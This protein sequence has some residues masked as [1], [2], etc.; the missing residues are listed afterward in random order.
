MSRR[1]LWPVV[2]TLSAAGV[3]VGHDFAY[4]FAGV[5]SDG[6]HGYLAH[7]PQ[8]L[9][10]LS[11]P[12]ALVALSGG[13]TRP[14]KPWAFGMLGAA[15]FTAMEHLERVGN[16]GVPWLLTSPLF[17]LGLALQL[18]FALAAWWIA[19]TLLALE[20]PA[21]GRPPR[22]PCLAFELPHAAG[23]PFPA[24]VRIRSRPRGPPGLL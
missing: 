2:L 20:L 11:L 1:L 15:G 24:T 9:V 19:R 18:P 22:R 5:G 8:L 7:A 21:R 13:R 12:A 3:L 16:G 6:L 4:R 17:L 23:A 10:A 14:P